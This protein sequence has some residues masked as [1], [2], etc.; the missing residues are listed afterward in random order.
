MIGLDPNIVL[1]FLTQDDP[2][3]SARANRIIEHK[4][5]TDTPGFISTVTLVETAWVLERAYGF[6]WKEIAG[7]IERILQTD[8][9]QAEGEQEVAIAMAALQAGRGSFADALIAALGAKAGCLYTLT[10]D[11]KALRLEGFRLA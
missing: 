1:R 2:E 7:A 4:L 8:V 6:M 11:R 3:Q 5:T 9:L 10:F